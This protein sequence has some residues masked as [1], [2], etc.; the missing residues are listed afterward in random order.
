MCHGNYG[1]VILNIFYKWKKNQ[2]DR[3]AHL[4]RMAVCVETRKL[5]AVRKTHTAQ[6]L[7]RQFGSLRNQRCIIHDD[8]KRKPLVSL[9]S[10][11]SLEPLSWKLM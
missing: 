3:G 11:F 2:N 8:K 9:Y 6:E 1:V 7:S 10:S 5:S 4:L